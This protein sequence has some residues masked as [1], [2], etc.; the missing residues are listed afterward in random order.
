LT[1]ALRRLL[2]PVPQHP[3]GRLV[4]RAINTLQAGQPI[5]LDLFASLLENGVDVEELS[6]LYAA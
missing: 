6:R 1:R 2:N 4:D 5:P 3:V